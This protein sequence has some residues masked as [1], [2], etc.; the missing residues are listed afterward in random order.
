[1]VDSHVALMCFCM[2]LTVVLLGSL[3]LNGDRSSRYTQIFLGML[4]SNLL[5]L[6]ADAISWFGDKRTDA[7]YS[8]IGM[9][10]QYLTGYGL[11]F[12][13]CWYLLGRLDRWGTWRWVRRV[14]LLLCGIGEG[15]TILSQWTGLFY[16]AMP[17]GGSQRG[18]GFWLSNVIALAALALVGGGVLFCRKEFSQRE[19]W[20]ALM[21]VLLPVALL[22]ADLVWN[23]LILMGL[24][25]TLILVLVFVNIQ[26][27]R[28]RRLREQDKE[29]AEK[30]IAI[31]LSQIQPHFLFNILG[32]IE[33]LCETDPPRAQEAT[34]ELARFLRGNM[35]SLQSTKT[36]PAS[37]ELEHVRCYLN[38]ERI[39]F[40]SKLRVEYD[41]GPM[42]FFL[43]ALSL[44][45]LVEN[46]VR[47]G[48]TKR[49]EGGTIQVTTSQTALYDQVTIRDDGVG[50]D[51]QSDREDGRYHVG[52]ENVRSR[53]AAQCGGSLFIH[54]KPGIGTVAQVRIP[55]NGKG[56][57]KENDNANYRGR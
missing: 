20:M 21:Y 34:D 41:I 44:Q 53:L 27:H 46:A 2:V 57:G 32:S 47:H 39:R 55:R 10:F 49:E 9:L 50:F 25:T 48:V 28:D 37:R 42:D 16:M 35:D 38:L 40:G 3:L 13:Y 15:L 14:V 56:Q 51:P 17:G 52:I 4:L 36:I 19:R 54:S 24:G 5:F 18:S 33:W 23:A 1:M 26:L 7:F 31:M 22:F 6:G 30:K 45:P 43:P 11:L 8:Q 12:L 29:L